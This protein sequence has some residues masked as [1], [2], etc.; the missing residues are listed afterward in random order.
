MQVCLH[1]CHVPWANDT[2]CMLLA[3]ILHCEG[4]FRLTNHQPVLVTRADR[5]FRGKRRC[6]W[7]T[8]GPH[9]A[10]ERETE[11]SGVKRVLGCNPTLVHPVLSI[12]GLLPK[13]HKRRIISKIMHPIV[14]VFLNCEWL[15]VIYIKIVHIPGT[16]IDLI[17]NNEKDTL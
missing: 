7:R 11:A 8:R 4:N 5:I 16:L 17:L 3:Y 1:G 2:G 10:R 14:C 12:P 6:N 9:K 13:P 15:L